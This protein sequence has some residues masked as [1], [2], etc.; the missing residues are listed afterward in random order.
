MCAYL[1]VQPL[2]NL[3][4]VARAGVVT[5][6]ARPD[7]G[8]GYAAKPVLRAAIG[9]EILLIHRRRGVAFAGVRKAAC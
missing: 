6:T 4:W 2:A 9:L 5:G 3:S 7:G 8:P 1:T